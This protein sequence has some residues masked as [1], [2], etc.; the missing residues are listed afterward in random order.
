MRIRDTPERERR[1]ERLKDATGDRTKSGAIDTACEFYLAMAAVDHGA[2]VGK[3]AELMDAASE[4]GSLT[5]PEIA[6]I[7]ST[8]QL[9]IDAE[10]TY[11]VGD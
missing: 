9:P 11:S 3:I 5:A 10:T 7:L 1:I 4:R 6:A 8:S 2:R